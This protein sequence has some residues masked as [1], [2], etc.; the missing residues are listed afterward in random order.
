MVAQSERDAV[1]S[2]DSLLGGS[3]AASRR[4]SP[5]AEYIDRVPK[6]ASHL[7]LITKS[8]RDGDLGRRQ[9]W[10]PERVDNSGEGTKVLV[11]HAALDPSGHCPG[12]I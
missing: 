7:L 6:L 9:L 11:K 12:R 5:L 4:A 1:V 2:E 3:P 10:L 8:P